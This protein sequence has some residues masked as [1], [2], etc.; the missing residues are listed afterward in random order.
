MYY[1]ANFEIYYPEEKQNKSVLPGSIVKGLGAGALVGGG[2]QYLDSQNL[3]KYSNAQK[4][5]VNN[6]RES[7]ETARVLNRSRNERLNRNNKPDYKRARDYYER[8]TRTNKTN[9]G[10]DPDKTTNQNIKQ[11]FYKNK[12]T[13]GKSISKRALR[14][15]GIVGAG[16]LGTSAL[17]GYG[18][19]MRK[20]D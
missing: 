12:F 4:E 15:A 13:K 16:V 20:G 1:M 3:K 6:A 2:Y 9:F 5:I 18:N 14:N 19:Q 17:L 7:G 11:N 10:F 8:M